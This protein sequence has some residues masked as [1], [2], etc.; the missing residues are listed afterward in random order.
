[1]RRVGQEG[2]LPVP[3]GYAR[4]FDPARRVALENRQKLGEHRLA[5]KSVDAIQ[6]VGIQYGERVHGVSVGKQYWRP[7]PAD[8]PSIASIT[9]E[10]RNAS[11]ISH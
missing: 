11:A 7:A 10:S 8:A 4:R 1:M 2:Q 6:R 3:Q 5:A 9:R